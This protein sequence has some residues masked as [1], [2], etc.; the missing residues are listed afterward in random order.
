MT[1]L[2]S[3]EDVIAALEE[4]PHL[5]SLIG[6]PEREGTQSDGFP[7]MPKTDRQLFRVLSDDHYPHEGF[8]QIT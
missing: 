8:T 3:P 6:E 1:Y 4:S 2:F 7:S 5:R